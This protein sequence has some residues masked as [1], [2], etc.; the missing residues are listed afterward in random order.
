[1]EPSDY[2][3]FEYTPINRRPVLRW[4][5]SARVALWVIPNIEFFSLKRACAGHPFDKAGTDVPTVRPWGQRDY[6]NRMGI[7]TVNGAI[8]FDPRFVGNPL[9]LRLDPHWAA[10]LR[11]CV[12]RGAYR[13]VPLPPMP[14][15]ESDVVAASLAADLE[16]LTLDD[17]EAAEQPEMPEYE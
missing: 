4:P 9:V 5:N 2:G 6:G 14:G 17:E 16:Q 12:E 7:P 13:G 15:S 3:P 1:M 8:R 10:L 11:Q